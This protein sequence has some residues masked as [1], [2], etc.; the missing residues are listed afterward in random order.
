MPS[1]NDDIVVTG[2]G[3]WSSHTYNVTTGKKLSS[4][5]CSHGQI[6]RLAIA[7]DSPSLY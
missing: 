3:D 6:K 2:S 5:I 4:C 7:K 1:C